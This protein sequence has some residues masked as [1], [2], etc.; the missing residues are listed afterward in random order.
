MVVIFGTRTRRN[1]I[2]FF[3]APC[4]R[5]G[6]VTD[7][8]RIWEKTAGH[9]YWIPIIPLRSKRYV[10]CGGCG[11]EKADHPELDR[12]PIGGVFGL[13]AEAAATTTQWSDAREPKGA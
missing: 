8:L 7:H 2:G 1:P 3:R 6:T 9:V 11:T 13:P 5:C 10:V 4:A 12:V